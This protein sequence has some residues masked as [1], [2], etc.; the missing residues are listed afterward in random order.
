MKIKVMILE[1]DNKE[2]GKKFEIPDLTE[3]TAN[4]IYFKLF[5]LCIE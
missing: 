5:E 4:A 2:T 1:N 3:F